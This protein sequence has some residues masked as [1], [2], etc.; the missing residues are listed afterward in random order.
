MTEQVLPLTALTAL[1]KIDA[2]LARIFADRK[3]LENSFRQ[4]QAE[5]I[6]LES[7]IR[8]REASHKERAAKCTREEHFQ[9]DE[10]EKLVNRRKQLSSLGNWKLQQAAEREIEHAARQLEALGDPIKLL[11]TEVQD[12]EMLVEDLREKFS[13]KKIEFE[14]FVAE[15]RATLAELERREGEYTRDRSQYA[16]QVPAKELAIYDSIKQRFPMNPLVPLKGGHTCAGCDMQLGA[17]VALEIGKGKLVKCRGCTRI[18][19]LEEPLPEGK[20]VPTE[21]A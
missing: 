9:R 11:K 5:L 13:A 17:Q 16:K 1:S 21:A 14:K 15:T 7:E 12:L 20:P 4:Q 10:T 2:G 18:L 8:L 19:F 3:S 6:K